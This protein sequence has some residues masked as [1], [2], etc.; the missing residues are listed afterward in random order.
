MVEDIKARTQGKRRWDQSFSP[1]E[2]GKRW[3]Y[4]ELG[5]L[6]PVQT[7]RGYETKLLREQLGLKKTSKKLAEVWEAHC[8]D[9][10]ALAYS[11]VGGKTAPDNKRLVCMAP[12]VWHHRQ[13]HRHRRS[14]IGG[15]HGYPAQP[16]LERFRFQI[17]LSSY[18]G[19][20]FRAC[21]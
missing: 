17:A 10:W 15:Q 9:A 19:S 18:V 3:F 2:V 5:K 4:V 20:G 13:L 8:V 12:F 14:R 1:L 16:R 11:V 6:A 7:K 21:E